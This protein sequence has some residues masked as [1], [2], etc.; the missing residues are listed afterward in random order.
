MEEQKSNEI[1]NENTQ[2]TIKIEEPTLPRENK[3]EPENENNSNYQANLKKNDDLSKNISETINKIENT[4]QNQEV[5]NKSD[6]NINKKENVSCK[7]KCPSC[8][9]KIACS[10]FVDFCDKKEREEYCKKRNKECF[11]IIV[12]LYYYVFLF[13]EFLVFFCILGKFLIYICDC[14]LTPWCKAISK[15]NDKYLKERKEMD[16]R[17]ETRYNK[18]RIEYLKNEKENMDRTIYFGGLAD[19]EYQAR[20]IEYKEAQYDKEIKDLEKKL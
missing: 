3:N 14:C 16:K 2:T 11:C 12:V 13:T 10:F 1:N 9:C 20:V 17:F 5:Q 4:I 18:E 8:F 7:E 19:P 15:S 6:N